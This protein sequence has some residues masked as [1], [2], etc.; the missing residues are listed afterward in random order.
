MRQLRRFAL[1]P[2]LIFLVSSPA[3]SNAQNYKSIVVFGDSLSDTGNDANL[4][5]LAYGFYFPG[6]I[7]DYTAGRFTDGY[8]TVP[9]AQNYKGVWVEQLAAM[10]PSHPT[11]TNSLDGGQDYAYGF[12]FTGGGTTFFIFNYPPLYAITID[13]VDLQITHYLATNPKIDDKTLFVVW[14]G[15]NDVLNATQPSDIVN[16]GVNQAA[17][18]ERL[19]SAGATQFVVPNLPPLGAIPRLNTTPYAP[20]VTAETVIYNNTLASGLKIVRDANSGKHLRIYPVDIFALFNRIIASPSSFGLADVTDSSQGNYML[21]PDTYLFWDGLHPTTHGHNIVALTAD[22]LIKHHQ[23]LADPK[24]N[25][26]DRDHDDDATNA[27]WG[28]FLTDGDRK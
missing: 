14:A 4:S 7:F 11:V 16:A 20:A 24:K 15:A 1:L 19:I 23:C 22:E 8:D 3:I 9:A 5:N 6:P 12:A 25:G 18:I 28:C 2:A 10:L 26:W 21:N 27:E 17:D 13:N